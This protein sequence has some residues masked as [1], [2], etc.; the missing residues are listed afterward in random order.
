MYREPNWKLLNDRASDEAISF[1][2]Q[3]ME[4]NQSL[5]PTAASLLSNNWIE[6]TQE[7]LQQ[8]KSEKIQIAESILEYSKKSQFQ[9]YI[10]RFMTKILD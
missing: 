6:G 5:R 7:T 3:C 9:R 4:K 10:C 2:K 8:V 1:I